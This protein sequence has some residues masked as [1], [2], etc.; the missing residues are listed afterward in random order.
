MPVITANNASSTL[1]SGISNVSASLTVQLGGGA[2]F[3]SPSS[4]NY[5]Y[6]TLQDAANNIEI[7]KCTARVNDTMTIVRAQNGTTARTFAPGDTVECRPVAAMFLID[8]LLPSQSGA[9]GQVLK[10]NGSAASWGNISQ[11]SV[12]GLTTEDIAEFAGVQVNNLV[13]FA[14]PG[15]RVRGD[16]SNVTHANRVLFQT[17][18]ANGASALA[19]I[20]NGSATVSVLRAYNSSDPDNAASATVSA[21]PST[22][23]IV[24]GKFG[25]GAYLPMTFQVNNAER[26]RLA[27]TGALLVAT[28]TDDAIHGL[29]V[30]HTARANSFHPKVRTLTSGPTNLTVND[31]VV[32]CDTS[33][34][35]FTVNLP[36]AA[37]AG[38]GYSC[39]IHIRA[40]G[41]GN[42]LTITVP[43]GEYMSTVLN[44]VATAAPGVN[45]LMVSDGVN[46]WFTCT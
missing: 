3:P 12:L 41:S 24:A 25:S 5:F 20:P 10:S 22:V 2:A 38:A 33:G 15:G 44:G 13:T 7:V 26:M 31:G 46:K 39:S 43:S 14:V 1:V 21:G 23:D 11:G 32:L 29:Q 16:M 28:T 45:Y 35:N 8:E 42:T 6:V 4:P 9:T 30:N 37:A 17:S 40:F 36:S 18:V 19:V 34:G 27:T